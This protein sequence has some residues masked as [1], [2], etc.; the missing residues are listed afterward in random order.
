MRL[1]GHLPFS[2]FKFTN[3]N[4]IWIIWLYI[5][6]LALGI[7]L[8]QK[9]KLTKHFIL[10]SSLF[11]LA[12]Q[13]QTE[14]FVNLQSFSSLHYEALV[15]KT[16][17]NKNI[18][19]CKAH[20]GLAGE[21]INIQLKKLD[22]KS[23]DWLIGDCKSLEIPVKNQINLHSQMPAKQI[24]LEKDLILKVSAQGALIIYKNFSALILFKPASS[25]NPNHFY[26]LLKFAYPKALNKNNLWN[27]S[28]KAE[29]CL[30]PHLSK[31]ERTES[32]NVLKDKCHKSI[33]YLAVK[34]I[35]I[36]TNGQV[37]SLKSKV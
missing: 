2:D 28:P 27:T 14:S 6:I 32:D 31:L 23:L 8:W 7:G 22:L 26:S 4:S 16:A 21:K 13:A 1:L 3:I 29:I 11:L 17:K 36:Q 10:A 19:I 20:D 18:L 33:S 30:M 9:Y 24:E 12:L 15:F 5:V 37:I 34:S 25:N 35:L